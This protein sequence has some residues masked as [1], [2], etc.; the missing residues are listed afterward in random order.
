MIRVVS[1]SPHSVPSPFLVARVTTRAGAAR[2]ELY[3]GILTASTVPGVGF[4]LSVVFPALR[5]HN[6][7][8][9]VKLD[10]S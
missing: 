3:G 10:R 8:H 7:V 5:F 1:T 2:A 6:G 9:G 4:S